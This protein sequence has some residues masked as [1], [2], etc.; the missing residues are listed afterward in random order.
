M[1]V[2]FEDQQKRR[3][4]LIIGFIV[5]ALAL[6]VLLILNFLDIMPQ[7][8]KDG[9]AVKEAQ[10][11]ELQQTAASKENV[12]DLDGA[13]EAYGKVEQAATEQ[14]NEEAKLDAQAK[15]QQIEQEKAEQQKILDEN[16]AYQEQQAREAG[17]E[18]LK[19]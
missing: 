18:N 8:S 16:K 4:N 13:K 6:A 19:D 2:V 7:K 11:T 17:A 3:R 14:N 12:N 1:S 15:V 9:E 5:L 10:L